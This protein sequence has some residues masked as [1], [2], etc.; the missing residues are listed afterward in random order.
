MSTPSFGAGED[1]TQHARGTLRERTLNSITRAVQATAGYAVLASVFGGGLIQLDFFN[2][3]WMILLGASAALVFIVVAVVEEIAR[4]RRC[5][6]ALVDVLADPRNPDAIIEEAR[7]ERDRLARDLD[8]TRA[9]LALFVAARS[10]LAPHA[11]P[12]AR[13]NSRP[14]TS[15]ES[16]TK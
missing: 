2:L 3:W 8:A 14:A 15:E 11:T 12:S 16:E 4:L 1:S 5:R 6:Q 9:Q 13:D 7:Q 10:I